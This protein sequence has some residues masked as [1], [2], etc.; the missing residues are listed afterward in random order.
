MN[1]QLS[2]R[3]FLQLTTATALSQVLQGCNN[4]QASLE[5]LFL[6][7]SIPVQ[8]IGDFRKTIT[9]ENKVNFK[10]QPQLYQIYDSLLKI[11]NHTQSDSINNNLLTKIFNKSVAYPGLMS[12]GDFWLA[13]AIKQN[14]LQP[15]SVNSLANWEKLPNS[16]QKLTRRDRQG[17]MTAQG[18]IY[19]APYP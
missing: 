7:N 15:L 8:L 6:A 14:L 18:N 9:K 1:Y 3:S 19:G 13:T 2:R 5:I 17:N 16:W 4:S 10:P 12:L 11:H